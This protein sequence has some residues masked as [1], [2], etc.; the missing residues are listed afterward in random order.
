MRIVALDENKIEM[1]EN[2]NALRTSAVANVLLRVVNLLLGI[3]TSITLA[4]YLSPAGFGTYSLIIAGVSVAAIPVV[5]GLPTLIVREAAE[6]IRQ[7]DW[8]H[9][10]GLQRRVYQLMACCLVVVAFGLAVWFEY[11]GDEFDQNHTYTLVCAAIL[12]PLMGLNSTRSAI[13]QAFR[14]PVASQVPE[15]LVRPIAFLLLLFLAHRY[16]VIDPGVAIASYCVATCLALLIGYLIL[17]VTISNYAVSKKIKTDVARKYETRSWTTS[18]FPLSAISGLGI[19]DG[20]IGLL[21]IGW[22]DTDSGVGLFR[23]AAIVGSISLLGQQAAN[24]GLA[25][26]ISGQRNSFG[27]SELQSD[28][29]SSVRMSFLFAIAVMAILVPFGEDLIVMAYGP[30]FLAAYQAMLVIVLGQVVSVACGPVALT[31][32]MLKLE[33]VTLVISVLGMALTVMLCLWTIPEFGLIGAAGAMTASKII[34]SI[35]MSVMVWKLVGL[36]TTVFDFRSRQVS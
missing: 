1:R 5:A 29:L 35:A 26:I 28:L 24:I 16:Y 32:N 7:K 21:M 2:N 30:E 25:P 15:S 12:I 3:A 4:R 31:L 19:L 6:Y 36:R 18:L 23:V 9:F 17:R 33:K 27:A 14:R 13:L 20:H 8:A 22:L 10:R 34:R 11:L